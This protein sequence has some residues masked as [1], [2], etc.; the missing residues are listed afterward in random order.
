P[1]S[2][3]PGGQRRRSPG[4][5]PRRAAPVPRAVRPATP[6]RRRHQGKAKQESWA[7]SSISR[8]ATRG[9]DSRDGRRGTPGIG[10]RQPGEPLSSVQ[11]PA[12]WRAE[13]NPMIGSSLGI[14]VERVL[15]RCIRGGWDKSPS[16]ALLCILF[17]KILGE[18]SPALVHRDALDKPLE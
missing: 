9:T 1:P 18:S 4:G 5:R 10:D 14:L 7:C 11:A 17:N 16:R 2:A 13:P 3:P 6:A 8:T 12:P 15:R